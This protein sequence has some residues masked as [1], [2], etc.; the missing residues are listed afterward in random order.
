M[1]E[2]PENIKYFALHC[3]PHHLPP[4]FAQKPLPSTNNH[5]PGFPRILPGCLYVQTS[6]YEYIFLLGT[7]IKITNRILSTVFCLY[8]VFIH[9]TI[10]CKLSSIKI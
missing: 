5:V 4:L 10:S 7:L 1:V 2:G 9:L 8:L 6:K 3:A